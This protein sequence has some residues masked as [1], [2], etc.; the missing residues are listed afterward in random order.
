M[1]LGLSNCKR[2][3]LTQ[4]GSITLAVVLAVGMVP[5]TQAVLSNVGLPTIAP[6]LADSPDC[7]S[8][9]GVS[10]GGTDATAACGGYDTN[11]NP[12]H[13]SGGGSYPPC[14]IGQYPWAWPLDTSNIDLST[15]YAAR[16]SDSVLIESLDGIKDDYFQAALDLSSPYFQWTGSNN[17]RTSNEQNSSSWFWL[18]AYPDM[19][20]KS[21]SIWKDPS[22]TPILDTI[23]GG[24][25]K[26]ADQREADLNNLAYKVT[27]PLTIGK[28]SV[29]SYYTSPFS[30]PTIILS[31]PTRANA[32][33]LFPPGQSINS[34]LNELGSPSGMLDAINSNVERAYG[35]SYF[36]L[37][38]YLY[39]TIKPTMESNE[40]NNAAH[41]SPVGLP[42]Y[43]EILDAT[44]NPVPS[45]SGST[46]SGIPVWSANDLNSDTA[47][48]DMQ[49][50]V[51]WQVIAEFTGYNP[52]FA[53]V[54][55]VDQAFNAV[56]KNNL[57]IAFNTPN[58]YTGE[59]G[60][61][62][63]PAFGQ[64]LGC[65][66]N[67]YDFTFF[68]VDMTHDR[69]A[70]CP[71]SSVSSNAT[72][73]VNPDGCYLLWARQ[74]IPPPA[75]TLPAWDDGKSKIL[76]AVQLIPDSSAVLVNQPF[77]VNAQA[78]AN[79]SLAISA[80]LQM[81]L[82]SD[83]AFGAAYPG[84]VDLY[85]TQ[86]GITLNLGEDAFAI[87]PRDSSKSITLLANSIT[88]VS[89]NAGSTSPYSFTLSGFTITPQSRLQQPKCAAAKTAALLMSLCGVGFRLDTYNQLQ[90]YF[91]IS[92][93]TWWDGEYYYNLAGTDGWCGTFNGSD[94]IA[95]GICSTI[96]Y[97]TDPLWYFKAWT[98]AWNF[99]T[100]VLGN[101]GAV[102]A[103]AP[104]YGINT[105]VDVGRSGSPM[106]DVS[107]WNSD[108][109]PNA[110]GAGFDIS[111]AQVQVQGQNG[112]GVIVPP[113]LGP[114]PTP[115]PSP[116]PKPTPSPSPQPTASPRPTPQP[117]A[118]PTPQPTARPTPQPTAQP[119]PTPQP[120][121]TGTVRTCRAGP[122]A[123]A[124]RSG[125]DA[126]GTLLG[127][128]TSGNTVTVYLPAV[129]G[130]VWGPF[131]TTPSPP[132]SVPASGNTWYK[133]SYV[134]GG[135]TIIGYVYSG[136]ISTLLAP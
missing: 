71:M 19:L 34:L 112:A 9:S 22:G 121:T 21:L 102:V 5:L 133:I 86:V 81:R 10:A 118:Q 109:S 24:K 114:I 97:N 2:R 115:T 49:S 64:G 53:S 126:S 124:V 16:K 136:G 100:T 131:I 40:M 134:S 14:S 119:T 107:Y 135:H 63:Y 31:P 120:T 104:A 128:L 98:P 37:S 42:V 6:V 58:P 90:P 23:V 45:T 89:R 74:R 65:G 78:D 32:T 50:G 29:T 12:I 26:P 94:T 28:V 55:D 30:K 59:L 69:S 62:Y 92:V 87:V 83:V 132:C 130:G 38:D 110:I 105:P 84:E 18:L 13:I 82:S 15:H 113:T 95:P 8:A 73:K 25:I 96:N 85:Y 52:Q 54:K 93:H 80:G 17:G 11:G 123:P 3:I 122:V 4:A 33:Y 57:D 48:S 56:V 46:I 39:R 75:I 51:S 35:L 60:M 125:P 47:Y 106:Y 27:L 79:G 72:Y 129:S 99:S 103:G 61:V 1:L 41:Q 88:G 77:T 76:G 44:G 68:G 91:H 116:S 7:L 111:V 117:T 108:G 67:P 101:N 127:R 36:N 70:S 20:A 43:I 66:A